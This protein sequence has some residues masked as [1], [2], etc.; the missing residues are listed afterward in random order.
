MTAKQY[1]TLRETLNLS[2]SALA[3]KIGVT[4]ET[5][6]RRETSRHKVPEESALAITALVLLTVSNE[7]KTP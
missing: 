5:V 7:G 2:Q 4:R 6:V 1:R 3:E